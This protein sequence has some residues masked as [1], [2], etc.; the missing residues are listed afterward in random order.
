MQR[1]AIL[2]AGHPH[3]DE[4]EHKGKGPENEPPKDPNWVHRW[5]QWLRPEGSDGSRSSPI[6]RPRSAALNSMSVRKEAV[7]TGLP[8]GSAA[9]VPCTDRKLANR[10][11]TIPLSYG[12]RQVESAEEFA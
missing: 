3:Q 9:V 10:F 2:P 12:S 1:R 7:R 5:S 4:N 11:R 8:D 6:V